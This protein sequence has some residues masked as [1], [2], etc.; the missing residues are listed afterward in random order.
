MIILFRKSGG[1]L[2]VTSVYDW[3]VLGGN[4]T[5]YCTRRENIRC[6][7]ALARDIFNHALEGKLLLLKASYDRGVLEI[8]ELVRVEE[9]LNAKSSHPK[10]PKEDKIFCPRRG[11]K[12]SVWANCHGWALREYVLKRLANAVIPQLTLNQR[13]RRS[14]ESAKNKIDACNH[15]ADV[16]DLRLCR[17]RCDL[18]E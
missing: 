7:N 11:Y 4:G 9:L 10:V 18:S 14:R 6:E 13:K 15:F 8:R 12:V 16:R 5:W 3:L 1:F 17:S 2:R